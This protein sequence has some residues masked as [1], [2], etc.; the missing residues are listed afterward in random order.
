MH[1]DVRSGRHDFMDSQTGAVRLRIQW[2]GPSVQVTGRD[3]QAGMVGIRTLWL[4]LMR[5]KCR[6]RDKDM[7]LIT[8]GGDC[9]EVA[10][11]CNRMGNNAYWSLLHTSHVLVS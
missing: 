11:I 4:L 1:N 7:C 8:R 2:H 3:L 6:L 10:H 5:Y 9:L